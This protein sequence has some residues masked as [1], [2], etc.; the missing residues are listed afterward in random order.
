MRGEPAG[1]AMSVAA[2]TCRVF[3]H[4]QGVL[5]WDVVRLRVWVV[6][7]VGA[8]RPGHGCVPLFVVSRAE[9]PGAAA[10]R[11]SCCA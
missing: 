7:S 3:H 1:S 2:G 6:R 10:V 4:G 8:C 5:G 9:Q 11:Q